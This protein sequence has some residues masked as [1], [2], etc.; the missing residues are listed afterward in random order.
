MQQIKN[1]TNFN[2][3][4]ALV[5]LL[6][7]FSYIM[8]PTFQTFATYTIV[9]L[10][11]LLILLFLF[12]EKLALN[13]SNYR[14]KAY[15]MVIIILAISANF[16]TIWPDFFK[17]ESLL[18]ITMIDDSDIA[19]NRYYKILVSRVMPQILFF[20]LA[21]VIV[22]FSYDFISTA[23]SLL[24]HAKKQAELKNNLIELNG[25]RNISHLTDSI[26][27]EYTMR[28]NESF[29]NLIERGL[30]ASSIENFYTQIGK[31]IISAS[32]GIA[33][34]YRYSTL[35]NSIE[36]AKLLIWSEYVIDC[37]SRHGKKGY[38][39]T[40]DTYSKMVENIIETFKDTKN[41]HFFTAHS[42]SIRQWM[43]DDKDDNK[44]EIWRKYRDNME[45]LV[46]SGADIERALVYYG[47][48]IKE[49]IEK[50]FG[51]YL[52][53]SGKVDKYIEELNEF[54]TEYHSKS[55]ENEEENEETRKSYLFVCP[56]TTL[57]IT[58]TEY[59]KDF[60]IVCNSEDRSPIMAIGISSDNDSSQSFQLFVVD[61]L[62]KNEDEPYEKYINH[63]LEE[64]ND[65]RT[66]KSDK[67]NLEKIIQNESST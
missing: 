26:Y 36:N 32:E 55:S 33:D 40:F 2:T 46:A 67:I 64:Y 25:D 58:N 22:T 15:L 9:A 4:L 51:Y 39:T 35:K 43:E 1:L 14:K 28:F 16:V 52:N 49:A 13:N 50:F 63:F 65:D 11:I 10:D 20:V 12:A 18:N 34:D 24:T 48:S 29:K 54:Y 23:E 8:A 62:D 38:L 59:L 66:R 44:N 37:R 19:I 7:V 57:G 3:F 53:D 42:T 56:K 30:S 45:E 27:D 47:D 5:L 17:Y 31:Y 21:G 61:F 41:I 60:F 6:I